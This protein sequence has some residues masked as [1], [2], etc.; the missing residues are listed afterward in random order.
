MKDL[1]KYETRLWKLLEEQGLNDLSQFHRSGFCDEIPLYSRQTEVAF[2]LDDAEEAHGILLRFALKFLNSVVAYEPHPKGY[3]AA[4][5]IW[6]FPDSL[7]VPNLF[8]SCGMIRQIE[9]KLI[10]KVPSSAFGKQMKKLAPKRSGDE[11]WEVLEDMS[12]LDDMIRVFVAP[13]RHPYQGYV[14]LDHFRRRART[15]K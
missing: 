6:D 12:T 3:F 10:L 9:E 8:A 2:L 15:V 4:I 13:A 7:I 5:T 1:S 14:T 11:R